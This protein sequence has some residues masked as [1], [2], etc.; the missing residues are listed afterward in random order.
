[1]KI[2]HFFIDRPIFATVLSILIILTG[3][4]SYLALPVAQYPEVVPPTIQVSAT[5]PG[6]SSEVVAKTVATPLEQQINGVEGMLYMSSQSSNTGSMSLNITFELGTDLDKAQVLVQNRVSVAEARLPEAVRRLGITTNKNSSDIMMV[7][8][9]YSPEDTYDQTYIANYASLQLIDHI[10]RIKGVGTTFLFGGSPYSMRIWLDPDKIAS[11]NLT[12]GDIVNA[13]REQNIQVSSGTLNQAPVSPQ[14]AFEIN[15]QTQGRLVD[16][17]Q[18]ES[19]IVKTGQEGQIVRL[20]DVARLELGSESY[21]TKGYLGKNEAVAII[22]FQRPGSN[23]LETADEILEK[24]EDLSKSFPPSLKH[25][26]IYNPTEFVAKSVDAVKITIAE[27]IIL[28]VIVIIVFLQSWRAS[29]IPIIAIPVS[30]IGTFAVMNL[31]GFSLNNLSLFGLV[32]A[33]GIV[34]DDAIVVVENIERLMEQGQSVREAAR[35]TMTEI[36]GA[37]IAMGLVLVAVF[38]P[39]AFIDGIS[40]QFYRQ[41]SITIAVATS[42]SVFVSL[43]LSPA[44]ANILFKQRHAQ[45]TEEEP[46]FQSQPI[47]YLFYHFNRGMNWSSNKYSNMVAKLI[48]LGALV[49]LVYLGLIAL[50]FLQ[51]DRVPGGFI[52]QQDSGYAIIAVQLPPGASLQR[53]DEVV[54][55][56][57]DQV[58][59]VD[60]I[61]NSVAFTGFS[62]ATF[63]NASNAA[64][65][66]PVFSDFSERE[67]SMGELIAEMNQITASIEDAFAIVIPPPS[68][69]GIGSGGGFK[70]MLQDRRERGLQVLESAM[71]ELA[72]AANQEPA[73]TNV[74]SFFETSTPQLFL[75][76]DRERAQRLGVPISRVFEALE[77][78][79]GSS[80]INDFNYLGRTFRVTAQADAPYRMTPDDISRIRVRNTNGN[81]VPLG[82]IAVFNDTAG[83][84]RL[85]RYNLYNAVDLFGAAAPGYSTG[86]AIETMERLAEKVLPDGIS[87]EWTELA[88]QEKN[89][90]NTAIF[91][92]VLA[93]L[94]VFLLLA[95]LYESW[96]LPLAII[97]IVPM[98]L[99]SAIT[100][101]SL[102]GM[103]NNILTQ[104]GLIVLVGLASKNAI[105]IVEFAKQ[106]E[107]EGLDIWTAVSDAAKLRLRPILMTSFAF[108]LG[109]TPLMLA[110][111]AGSEMR[112]ALGVAVFSGMLGVTFFGLIFTPVFYVLCR[113]LEGIFKPNNLVS[114]ES[115]LK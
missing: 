27:A 10:A 79:L 61:S 81:M 53:T 96:T 1:V 83:P 100:G 72:G 71:W 31:L 88:L 62:G 5:Y 64:A 15:V 4:I 56:I 59:K 76:I 57:I 70:M 74:F 87:Y 51:F 91:A 98:C 86:D 28:V 42:I 73:T 110:S 38:V 75:D 17:Q 11:L 30:L 101:V 21:A 113:K 45:A 102:A 8:N 22:I 99:L 40:G 106:K 105:L 90:G 77:I 104:I 44:L 97:L 19:I 93:V 95:A 67:K 114:V 24:M 108:I 92:F 32:L 29:I 2:A 18:F 55:T 65:I 35:N 82:S 33:I 115:E 36:G 107:D 34:V 14:N 89:S 111:G 46:K 20:R 23:A 16:Q 84:S 3:A 78:Y 58:L 80:F 109:V 69:P 50:A 41:F 94:F 6:A 25:D 9:L 37:L 39:T 26:I 66:F 54:N 43:T 85:P 63:S 49:S 13:L 7:V 48:K 52:P 112:Q 12:A 103:D 68:V 47:G 60:G